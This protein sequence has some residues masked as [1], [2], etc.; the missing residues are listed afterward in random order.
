MFLFAFIVLFFHLMLCS[1]YVL[2]LCFDKGGNVWCGLC[3]ANNAWK[4][5][6]EREKR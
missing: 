1:Y 5:R 3:R 4:K 6:E 2:D